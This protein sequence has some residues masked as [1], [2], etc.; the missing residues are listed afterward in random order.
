MEII[1]DRLSNIEFYQS[2]NISNGRNICDF[3]I[4][5]YTGSYVGIKGDI[6]TALNPESRVSWH[7]TIGRDGSIKQTANFRQIAWHAG[8]SFWNAKQVNRTYTNLNKYSIGIEL[9]NAGLL[10]KKDN[11]FYTAYG[12]E[13]PLSN[14]FMDTTNNTWELFSENQINLCNEIALKLAKHYNCVDILGHNEIAPDRKV[15]PGS[16]FPLQ[17]LK[18]KLYAQSW[19]KW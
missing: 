6:N 2:P 3:I 13:V 17:D 7:L 11:K 5:H 1:Y 9:D 10:T 8:K 16:A 19:Y 15:D 12:Q 4:I 18:E 14:V